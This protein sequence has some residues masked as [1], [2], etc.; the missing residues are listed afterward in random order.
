MASPAR[1]LAKCVVRWIYQQAAELLEKLKQFLLLIISYIDAQI[2]ILRAWLAQFDVLARIEE[3]A[4]AVV[5]EALNTLRNQMTSLPGGPLAEFCPEFYSYFLD[6]ALALF[7]AAVAN[8]TIFRERFHNMISF[9]DEVDLAIAY[10]EQIKI[11]LVASVE[12]LDDAILIALS[13]AADAV[14]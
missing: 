13:N 6:P 2:A 4:W 3:A 10:W 8:L 7:D 1:P 12:I 9:M 11:D 14:P 5:Q